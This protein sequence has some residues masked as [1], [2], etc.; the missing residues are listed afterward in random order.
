MRARSAVRAG[1]PDGLARLVEDDYVDP[2]PELALQ[3]G[4]DVELQVVQRLRCARQQEGDVD[5][6]R[7]RGGPSRLAPEEVG[8][9]QTFDSC[10]S[11]DDEVPS[12]L[13]SIANGR[14]PAHRRV[15]EALKGA[16]GPNAS[17]AWSG[18][19]RERNRGD[20]RTRVGDAPTVS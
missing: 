15:L 2:Q 6:A 9:D 14:R 20:Y 4:R 7:G 17:H 11:R 1:T 18:R 19:P 3:I 5:V 16:G 10:E 13:E 8:G 12:H